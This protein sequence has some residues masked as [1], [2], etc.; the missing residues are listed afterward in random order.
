MN[1]KFADMTEQ[2]RARWL[3]WARS[4]DWCGDAKARYV[5]HEILGIAMR[6]TSGFADT[7]AVEIA[8]HATPK[9]LRDWAGY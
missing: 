9:D 4:H 3:T 8:F 6:T 2:Q 5:N 7:D 1:T